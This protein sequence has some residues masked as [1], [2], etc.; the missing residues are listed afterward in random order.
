MPSG[1]DF[2]S[3]GRLELSPSIPQADLK[4]TQSG[5]RK[6]TA[7]SDTDSQIATE[8]WPGIKN[9][10]GGSGLVNDK[11]KGQCANNLCALSRPQELTPIKP[12]ATSTGLWTNQNF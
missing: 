7:I 6:Q 8:K 4:Q 1:L 11:I 10:K 5:H 3:Y 2:F 12:I 9:I